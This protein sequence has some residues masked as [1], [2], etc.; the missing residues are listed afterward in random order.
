MRLCYSIN[1]MDCHGY[2]VLERLLFVLQTTESS[3]FLKEM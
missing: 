3:L 2:T 1:N